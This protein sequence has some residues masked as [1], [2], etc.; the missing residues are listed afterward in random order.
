[1]YRFFEL[2][3]T[4]SK[5]H[6][7]R[8]CA[9]DYWTELSETIRTAAITGNIRGLYEGIKTAMG[10]TQNKTAPLK[11]TTGEVI[12]DKGQQMERWVEHYSEL[13]SRQ[14]VV[15]T[16]ALDGIKCLNDMGEFD[17]EP[18][19]DE[20]SKAINTLSSRKAPGSNGIPPDLIK[21]CKTALL[22]PL[23]EVLC[24]CWKEG[25]VPQDTR[26]ANIV[27]L[28]KNKGERS[29]CNNYRAIYLL[30]TVN[31]VFAR[32]ILVRLAERVYPESQCGFRAERSTIDMVFSLHQLQEKCR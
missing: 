32:V 23:H 26:D 9:H 21:H 1:M 16:S 22:A 28:Y 13:Y 30:S 31:K 18:I 4:K 6:T 14:N 3:G 19:I 29:D 27:T 25:A 2:Q 7:A 24:E 15:T 17:N 10:P 5:K 8:R 12:T 11:S 20:L